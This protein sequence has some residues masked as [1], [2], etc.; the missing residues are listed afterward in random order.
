MEVTLELILKTE[1]VCAS[2]EVAR[3]EG[4]RTKAGVYEV[5]HQGK[6]WG[7]QK[8]NKGVYNQICIMKQKFWL[9]GYPKAGKPVRWWLQDS[10]WGGR[11]GSAGTGGTRMGHSKKEQANLASLD[12]SMVL[13]SRIVGSSTSVL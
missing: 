4:N 10:E 12:H 9:R 6:Y 3:E 13:G 1:Y 8:A 5:E 11:G 7:P 2:Q